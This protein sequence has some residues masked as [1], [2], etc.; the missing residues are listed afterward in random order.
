MAAPSNNPYHSHTFAELHELPTV[1]RDDALAGRV[2]LVTGAA[3]GIG[4]AI[5]VLCA[6]L[7]ASLVLC[8]RTA[9]SLDEL[10]GKLRSRGTEV[11]TRTATVRD[12]EQV[13]AVVDAAWEHFG[14]L[15]V[16]VNNAGGQFSAPALDIS[17]K[18]WHAVVETNLY[19]SWF[20]MQ[21][22]ARR[23]AEAGEP[24]ATE[25]R[26]VVNIST[27]I[28]NGGAGIAHTAAARAGQINLTRYLAVEW[29]P[30]HIRANAIAVGV[31]ASEGLATY[32]EAARASF[33]HNPMRRLGDVWD[34]AQG[35]VYLAAPS[36]A[37]ITGTTLE[38]TG[39]EH[40]WGEYWPLGRPDYFEGAPYP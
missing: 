20:M 10:A 18:G 26:C 17:P 35:V 13:A 25:D 16:V 28:G 9:A 15:D 34:V 5:S 2:V 39:G 33:G 12:P 38:I 24:G 11:I 3:G 23:W 21:A 4:S 1:Y 8:G 27:I 7:G 37:F 31:V 6:R 36:A 40:V 14:H 32:P 30:L 29:A 19:G 22:A